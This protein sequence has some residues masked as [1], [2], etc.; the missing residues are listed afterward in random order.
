MTVADNVPFSLSL[1]H[2]IPPLF[3]HPEKA[4]VFKELLECSHPQIAL[5]EYTQGLP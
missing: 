4:S 2:L 5:N 1:D 3:T